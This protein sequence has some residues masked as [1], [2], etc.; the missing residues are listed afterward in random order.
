MRRNIATRSWFRGKRGG[1]RREIVNEVANCA[2]QAAEDGPPVGET[3]LVVMA[4]VEGVEDGEEGREG[5][6]GEWW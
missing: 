4:V 6:C 2:A 1:R 5:V 3:V